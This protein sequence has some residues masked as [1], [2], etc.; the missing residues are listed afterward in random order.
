MIFIFLSL[1]LKMSRIYVMRLEDDKYYVGETSNIDSLRRNPQK[2]RS[3][4]AGLHVPIEVLA[5]Y[6]KTLC[7]NSIVRYYMLQYGIENVRGGF[8]SSNEI[9]EEQL[10]TL[11]TYFAELNESMSI[12]EFDRACKSISRRLQDEYVSNVF[13]RNNRRRHHRTGQQE[14]VI[15]SRRIPL[16]GNVSVASDLAKPE[17]AITWQHELHCPQCREIFVVNNKTRLFKG[18]QN[19]CCACEENSAEV[20][21]DHCNALFL[22][23]HCAKLT[24]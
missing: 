20:A 4:W 22:C 6:P 2:I 7:K 1:S 19:L 13:S 5:D 23:L 10:M 11:S 17:V 16:A 24:K 12:E 14:I 3:N 8:Y 15:V 9:T 18:I 21:C